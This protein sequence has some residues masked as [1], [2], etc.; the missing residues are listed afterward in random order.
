MF[1]PYAV[2]EQARSSGVSLYAYCLMPDHL[3]LLASPSG[4]TSLVSFVQAIKSKST[5]LAWQH[6][7][8]GVIWQQR[9]YDHFLRQDED[10]RQ[11]ATYILNNPVRKGIVGDRRDYPYCGSLVYEL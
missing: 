2:V 10:I 4:G 7:Y 6:G 8:S 3:H 5:R 11:A 9:F 1:L